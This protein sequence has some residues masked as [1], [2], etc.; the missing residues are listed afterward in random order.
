MSAFD[1]PLKAH[2]IAAIMATFMMGIMLWGLVGFPLYPE[3]KEIT[4]SSAT[5]TDLPEHPSPLSNANCEIIDTSGVL[6]YLD[7]NIQS[8][9]WC[10]QGWNRTEEIHSGQRYNIQ[11][12]HGLIEPYGHPKI[13]TMVRL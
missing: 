4:I 2:Y 8:T 12:W 7:Q 13:N 5:I 11:I 1:L 3:H 6:Y 10:V 9:Y